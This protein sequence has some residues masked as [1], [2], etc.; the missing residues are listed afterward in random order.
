MAAS[1]QVIQARALNCTQTGPSVWRFPSFSL[2]LVILGIRAACAH[3]ECGAYLIAGVSIGS[4][5]VQAC[6]GLP[7]LILYPHRD[8]PQITLRCRLCVCSICLLILDS[9]L[10]LCS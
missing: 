2:S 4:T 7:Q 10:R 5:E 1:M 6:S 9:V 8:C 3:R